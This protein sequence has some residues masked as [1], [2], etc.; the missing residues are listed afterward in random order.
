MDLGTRRLAVEISEAVVDLPGLRR[1]VPAL[2]ASALPPGLASARARLAADVDGAL[3]SPGEMR[4][5]VPHLDVELAGGHLAG[6]IELV[7]LDEPRRVSFELS[8]AGLDLDQLA[9]ASP[10]SPHAPAK[11]APALLHRIEVEGR[12]RLASARVRG[13]ALRD[14]EAAI[15]LAGGRLAFPALR[16]GVWDGALSASGAS[17]DFSVQPPR[18]G[19]PARLDRVDLAQLS[20]PGDGRTGPQL[21]GRG[22]LGVVLDGQLPAPGAPLQ[23]AGPIEL[24]ITGAQVRAGSSVRA[25]VVNPLVNA[26]QQRGAAQARPR[27]EVMHVEEL[28]ARVMLRDGGLQTLRPLHAVIDEGTLDLEGRLGADHRVDLSGVFTLSPDGLERATS[29]RVALARPVAIGLRFSGVPPGIKIELLD[30]RRAVGDFMGSMIDGSINRVIARQLPP[31]AMEPVPDEP[32]GGA[33]QKVAPPA[34]R[35][36]RRSRPTRR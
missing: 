18:L 27:P 26:A 35:H 28:R 31:V 15:R 25:T 13:V 36:P 11:E 10:P 30:Q 9:T 6:R 23:L 19:L 22:T 14:L 17:I 8:G 2:S 21:T 1:V 29:G 32:E 12:L 34:P 24:V 5:V 33:K 3:G 16:A 4:L 20:A 7:G